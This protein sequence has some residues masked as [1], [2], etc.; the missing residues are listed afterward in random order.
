MAGMR[1]CVV[2]C[3]PDGQIA[4]NLD[5][6]A[7]ATVRHAIEISG[8]TRTRPEIDLANQAV[9]IFGERVTLDKPVEDGDRIEI[10]RVLIADPKAARRARAARPR[11]SR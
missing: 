4:I 8:I 5:L 2:Y 3:P 6:P 1:V 9:G 10:Y 11:K 7:G